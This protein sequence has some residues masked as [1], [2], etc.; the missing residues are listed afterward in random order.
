M[1]RVRLRRD[2]PAH[3][4]ARH[5]GQPEV[6]DDEIRGALVHLSQGREAIARLRHLESSEYERDPKCVAQLLVI[7]DNQ[8]SRTH[9]PQDSAF[10]V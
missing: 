5:V 8:D 2:F 10:I 3:R 7:L 9:R 6:E 1:S 4:N